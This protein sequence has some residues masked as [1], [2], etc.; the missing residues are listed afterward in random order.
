M[1][2]IG[3]NRLLQL[4]VS[5]PIAA[6]MTFG[7]ILVLQTVGSYREAERLTALENPRYRRQRS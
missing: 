2:K 4:A 3:L 5:L 1:Q 7:L 6:M